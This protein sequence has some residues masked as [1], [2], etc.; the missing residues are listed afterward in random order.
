M[1]IIVSGLPGIRI[2]CK[3]ILTL[4]SHKMKIALQ[5]NSEVLHAVFEI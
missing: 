4:K 3:T 1:H 5:F 2:E